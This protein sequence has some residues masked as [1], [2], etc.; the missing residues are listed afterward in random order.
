M[1]F[2]PSLSGSSRLLKLREF[3]GGKFPSPVSGRTTFCGLQ[4]KKF[5]F[6]VSQ[7]KRP[8]AFLS[9]QSRI[10]TV[11]KHKVH[12]QSCTDYITVFSVS[13][14]FTTAS[15]SLT[16]LSGEKVNSITNKTHN[17]HNKFT[18]VPSDIQ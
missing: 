16:K 6:A 8:M 17:S 7:E 10:G 14:S 18:N 5:D 13:P 11:I 12:D 1:S 2:S 3:V 4:T 9:R 15:F